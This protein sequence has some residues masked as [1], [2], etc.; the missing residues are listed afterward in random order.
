MIGSGPPPSVLV[1]F[2]AWHF[3]HRMPLKVAAM[4]S[5]LSAHDLHRASIASQG[6]TT[7]LWVPHYRRSKLANCVAKA[8]AGANTDPLRSSY[9]KCLLTNHQLICRWHR[10]MADA[11][12]QKVT[13]KP[14][15]VQEP[16]SLHAFILSTTSL[17]LSA[18]PFQGGVTKNAKHF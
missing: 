12:G 6:P 7:F 5:R 15:I 11:A 3:P 10:R 14:V 8:A 9:A 17:N 4:P 18:N 2:A 13:K 1:I 16:S